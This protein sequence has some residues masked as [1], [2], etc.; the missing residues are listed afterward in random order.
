MMPDHREVEATNVERQKRADACRRQRR[1]DGELV[2]EALV[3]DA[4]DDVD[5]DERRCVISAGSLAS[6]V[7]NAWALPWKV[8]ITEDGRVEFHAPPRWP[9]S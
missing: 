6:E 2:N 1:K 8:A 4:E 5:D 9:A 3:E 7:W